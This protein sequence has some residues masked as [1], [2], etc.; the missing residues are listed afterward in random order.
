[1]RTYVKINT[2]VELKKLGFDPEYFFVNN[3]QKQA[4]GMKMAKRLID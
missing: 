2:I 4:D 1:M 3:R